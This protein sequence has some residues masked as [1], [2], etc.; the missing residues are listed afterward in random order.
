MSKLLCFTW[1]AAGLATP[2]VFFRRLSEGI[3][4]TE[5]MGTDCLIALLSVEETCPAIFNDGWSNETLAQ[6]QELC[7]DDACVTALRATRAPCESF[8]LEDD[9]TSVISEL[10]GDCSSDL[11]QTCENTC[12]SCRQYLFQEEAPAECQ[13][14]RPCTPYL[15]C[16]HDK[17]DDPCFPSTATVWYAN[18]QAIPMEHVRVGDELLVAKR[19]GTLGTDVV[20]PW[21]VADRA[22]RNATFVK[23][24]TQ[25]GV[26]VELTQFHRVAVGPT[27]C[28]EHVEARFLTEG[29]RV[30]IHNSGTPK[31]V[32]DVVRKLSKVGA[33]GRFSPVMVSGGLPIVD[34]LVT[35][36]TED[37][38]L[39]LLERYGAIV[40]AV[41]FLSKLVDWI[42][43]E[44]HPR[45]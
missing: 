32:A 14:C 26:E 39:Q 21:S 34:G 20:S 27:C 16:E 35:A 10:C 42:G 41:P 31:P 45:M 22:V 23:V 17:E 19:D 18:G 37:S 13:T 28:T 44:Q 29:M 43:L 30:W 2:D 33:D 6:L 4:T 1:L 12:G 36:P 5:P 15:H 3:T 8:F 40:H 9:I 25:R 24:V 38:N 11:A 7:S